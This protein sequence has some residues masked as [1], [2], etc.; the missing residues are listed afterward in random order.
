[1]DK[2]IL[3]TG[4]SGLL[5]QAL[6]THF[7]KE[8]FHVVAQYHS[9]QP[10]SNPQC[11]WLYADFSNLEGIRHFL[12]HNKNVI[13]QC[14]Y[15]I[16]NYGPITNKDTVELRAEDFLHDYHHNVIT[17]FEITQ[18]LLKAGALKKVV[19]IGFEF[20]GENRAYRK[21]V[22]YAAAKNALSLMTQALQLQY[23][24]VQFI[25]EPLRTLENAE[26][27]PKGHQIISPETAAGEIY[28][29]LFCE[30]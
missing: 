21:I 10:F 8:G 2:K 23:P 27:S 18:F 29:K 19:N 7:I 1:M 6:V 17:A 26:V 15:L 28:K 4:A 5:G 12:Q 30:S 9:H 24:Q 22:T 11:T 14:A 3:I 13:S 20:V 25:I 16:N